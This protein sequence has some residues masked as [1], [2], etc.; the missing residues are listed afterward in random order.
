MYTYQKPALYCI[1]IDEI[2]STISIPQVIGVSPQLF[3]SELG[4]HLNL[5]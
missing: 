2:I 1:T 5:D 3:R 4:H